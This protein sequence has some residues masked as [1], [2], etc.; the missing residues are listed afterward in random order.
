MGKKVRVLVISE[1]VFPEVF[2]GIRKIDAEKRGQE[3]V[4]RTFKTSPNS[5]CL[6]GT[7]VEYLVP[8]RLAEKIKGVGNRDGWLGSPDFTMSDGS[9]ESRK[10]YEIRS[11]S[12]KYYF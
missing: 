4:N 12:P 3:C 1:G 8:K 9:F 5:L 7:S 2:V 6:H 11:F 10:K